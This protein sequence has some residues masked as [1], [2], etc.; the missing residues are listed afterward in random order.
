MKRLT[1]PL[2]ALAA[3]SA[4]DS[5]APEEAE[6]SAATETGSVAPQPAETAAPSPAPTAIPAAI[7]GRW[8]MNTADCEPGRSDNKGLLTISANQLE[9][10]ESVGTLDQIEEASPTRI[11]A[12]F[13]FMGEGMEWERD[14]TLTVEDGGEALVRREEGE[15]A[16]PDA[17]RYDKCE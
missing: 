6:P 16:A 3:L 1:L 11:R 10:Y 14:V 5:N 8:G 13:D 4:C 9:F 12:S 7:Q 15:G 17:F 2:L